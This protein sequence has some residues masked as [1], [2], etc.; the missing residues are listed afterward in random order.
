MQDTNNY[1]YT[2]WVPCING[3]LDFG[4][5]QVGLRGGFTKNKKDKNV[6]F[7]NYSPAGYNDSHER[8][9]SMQ[10]WVDWSDRI[11]GDGVFRVCMIA[12]AEKAN[13]VDDRILKGKI[14]IYAKC[15]E[16][17][18]GTYHG[19]LLDKIH[20]MHNAY[21]E[22]IKVRGVDAWNETQKNLNSTFCEINKIISEAESA[23]GDPKRALIADSES[24]TVQQEVY[25]VD[26]LVQC[27][28]L[29]FLN[30]RDLN[31]H[32]GIESEDKFVICRQAFYYLKYS[33]HMHKHHEVKAD[34]LTTIVENDAAVCGMKSG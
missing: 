29:S 7:V 30:F 15:Y 32:E 25:I 31:M 16:T 8:N 23:L 26:F 10:S 3:H 34:A 12:Q 13:S 5:T 22:Y 28:G 14:I 19:V 33:L 18:N 20:D 27:D 17:E 21:K 2:G 4:L 9:I 24:N 1:K 11:E 6:S